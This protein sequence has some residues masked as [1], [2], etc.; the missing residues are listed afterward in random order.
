MI[1]LVERLNTEYDVQ[2]ISSREAAERALDRLT[3]SVLVY[4]V[5]TL[6]LLFSLGCESETRQLHLWQVYLKSCYLLCRL[7]FFL[8]QWIIWMIRQLAR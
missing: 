1:K 3:V 2:N 7:F 5:F 8:I 4:Q 6:K